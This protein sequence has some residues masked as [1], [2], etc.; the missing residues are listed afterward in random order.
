MR[1]TLGILPSAS[2]ETVTMISSAHNL[3][4][5]GPPASPPARPPRTPRMLYRVHMVTYVR[6]RYGDP[7]RALSR[8]F[9]DEPPFHSHCLRRV[10]SNSIH[11]QS[12]QFTLSL[13]V[14][15]KKEA[16]LAPKGIALGQPWRSIPP[17]HGH[18]DRRADLLGAALE[19][20]QEL[21]GTCTIQLR[22]AAVATA[23]RSSSALLRE[24]AKFCALPAL[25]RRA[26]LMHAGWTWSR[27]A[28]EG[29]GCAH[30]RARDRQ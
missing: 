4:M 26:R 17:R 11:R 25:T 7:Y 13:E 9:V 6:R 20:A 2:L 10:E 21:D 12:F 29:R 1:K 24:R 14:G 19:A 8:S 22:G 27:G 5:L 28:L 15:A 16:A 30:R 18:Q 3:H 23:E